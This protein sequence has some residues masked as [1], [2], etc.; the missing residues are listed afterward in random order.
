MTTNFQK[1]LNTNNSLKRKFIDSSNGDS[2]TDYGVDSDIKQ[3]VKI[4]NS[5][6]TRNAV[7]LTLLDQL[8]QQQLQ[9][10]LLQKKLYTCRN[11]VD[12]EEV[13]TRYLKLDLNNEQVKNSEFMDEKNVLSKKLYQRSLMVG[14][15]FSLILAVV[16]YHFI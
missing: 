13:K 12:V 3:P 4:R 1:T 16:V 2:D 14:I 5:T 10:Q 9:I 11:E 6:N 7:D 15:E 8:L